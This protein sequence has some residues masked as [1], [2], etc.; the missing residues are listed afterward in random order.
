MD[1]GRGEDKDARVEL[2]LVGKIWTKRI[3]NMN[4]FMSTMKNE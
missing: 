2:G 3:I 4:A 1:R